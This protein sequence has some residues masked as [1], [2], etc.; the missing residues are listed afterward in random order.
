MSHESPSSPDPDFDA[1][2]GIP[3][4]RREIL[5]ARIERWL[6][7][8]RAA[9]APL[10]DDPEAVVQRL[11]SLAASAYAARDDEL[12]RLDLRRSLAPDWFQRP[13]IVGYAAYA[14]RFGGTLAGVAERVDYLKL[15]GVGYL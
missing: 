14:D 12:H 3:P 7:D 1:L 13:E 11:L 9:V 2:E 4:L 5:E 8:L 6:P 10:Y 15:L